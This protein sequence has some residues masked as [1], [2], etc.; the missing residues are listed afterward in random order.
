MAKR[1]KEK[2]LPSDVQL[3]A[4]NRR[5]SFDYELS[6]RF[7]AGLVLVGSEVKSL[8]NRNASIS[9]AW[10]TTKNGEAFIEGMRI[11][12]LKH[13]A[14]G[15]AKEKRSRKLLLHREEIQR[16]QKA[17]ERQ[18]MTLVVTQLY[19]RRGKAKVEIALARGKRAADKRQ[20]IKERDA[21]REARAAIDRGRKGK[22]G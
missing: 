6:D 14:F 9:E 5:A 10:A 20:S 18:G 21:A 17:I 11:G 16:L 3:I 22:L 4:T 7:E 12:V 13:A 8:R 2:K 19:F 15:H 1:K